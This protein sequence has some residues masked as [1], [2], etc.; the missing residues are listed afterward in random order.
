MLR[1]S[2]IVQDDNINI[3][4]P[5]ETRTAAKIKIALDIQRNNREMTNYFK[6]SNIQDIHSTDVDSY[7]TDNLFEQKQPTK[8]HKHTKTSEIEGILSRQGKTQGQGLRSGTGSF[9]GSF[10]T[11]S[12]EPKRP[13]I[14]KAEARQK[15]INNMQSY[16]MKSYETYRNNFY[17]NAERN[18]PGQQSPPAKEPPS[19]ST[20]NSPTFIRRLFP[21]T[22]A[23]KDQLQAKR[24]EEQALPIDACQFVD[25][26]A[27]EPKID[28]KEKSVYERQADAFKDK[29]RQVR[30]FRIDV[31]TSFTKET[32]PSISTQA[33]GGSMYQI[34]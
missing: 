5:L 34:N 16:L 28:L 11:S 33:S 20:S 2:F 27:S 30:F 19:P 14:T 26:Y 1:N 3:E 4:D 23:K 25:Y 24:K 21:A 6:N 17:N 13:S 8:R 31:N 12:P 7:L 22:F 10:E 29:A 15:A 18:R 32:K 9:I